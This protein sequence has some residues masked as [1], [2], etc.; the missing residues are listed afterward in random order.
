MP[1][2]VT[3]KKIT[4]YTEEDVCIVSKRDPCVIW[5]GTKVMHSGYAGSTPQQASGYNYGSGETD[6]EPIS[7]SGWG[8][9]RIPEMNQMAKIFVFPKP[10][11]IF[12]HPD[13]I[14]MPAGYTAESGYG[15]CSGKVA[16]LKWCSACSGVDPTA[17]GTIWAHGGGLCSGAV[18]IS[19]H[20]TSGLVDIIA[21]GSEY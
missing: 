1:E 12:A 17:S 10:C 5:A 19:G 9:I 18:W 3:G 4:P 16:L 14:S 7:D 2:K 15:G 11:W 6:I 13:F 21:F 20:F 8:H